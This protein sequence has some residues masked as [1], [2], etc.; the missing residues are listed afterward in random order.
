M[1]QRRWP[2][3]SMLPGSESFMK[4]P[5]DILP[6]P[7]YLDWGHHM[8]SHDP[9]PTFPI[10]Q[11]IDRWYVEQLSAFLQNLQSIPDGN[12]TLLDNSF[13]NTSAMYAHDTSYSAPDY[14]S[15]AIRP[16]D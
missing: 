8:C 11:A 6:D 5:T 7:Q 2:T 1:H 4:L 13:G 14:D 3:T 10:I 9:K 16:R 15:S 12:G